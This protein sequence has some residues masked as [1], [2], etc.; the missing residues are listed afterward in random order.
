MWREGL[1]AIVAFNLSLILDYFLIGHTTW[2]GT[3][4]HT[5]LV[6]PI[7]LTVNEIVRRNPPRWLRE[8]SVAAGMFL[9]CQVNFLVEGHATA[10]STLFGSICM[11]ITALFVGVVMRLR[12]PY[13]VATLSAM[14]FTDLWRLADSTTLGKSDSVMAAS[15]IA[16]GITLIAIA[17]TS[18]ESEER[19][20]YLLGLERDRQA[21]ELAWVNQSLLERANVDELTR[22][23]NRR[24]LDERAALQW[25]S[26]A[27]ASEPLS[28]IVVDIDHFKSVNDTYGHLFGDETLRHIGALLPQAIRTPTDMAARFGGEEFVVLLPSS[29]HEA[30]MVV[31]ERIRH[32]IEMAEPP[33]PAHTGQPNQFRL[34]VSCGVSTCQPGGQHIWNEVLLAADKGLYAA[35]HNGRN[36]VE[37][38]S[39][40]E[41]I[42]RQRRAADN[43]PSRLRRISGLRQALGSGSRSAAPNA[44]A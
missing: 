43:Q 8:G 41:G 24:A 4:T 28:V 19:N 14:L 2:G 10:A 44:N 39:C 17:S 15:M 21:S 13:V 20:G 11:L 27:L 26:C 42:T 29:D 34:T 12:F 16:I 9:I 6:T 38:V 1:I 25:Q 32:L 35:K 3:V 36:R 37:F 18:L 40:E 23:P 30:A 31:A 5:A 33:N 7:S 22:L